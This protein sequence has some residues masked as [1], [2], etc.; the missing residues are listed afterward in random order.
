MS[1]DMGCSFIEL[2]LELNCRQLGCLQFFHFTQ[3]CRKLVTIQFHLN[4]GNGLFKMQ[5]I[6][7]QILKM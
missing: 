6:L 5:P 3:L 7:K 2:K 1:F 4:E